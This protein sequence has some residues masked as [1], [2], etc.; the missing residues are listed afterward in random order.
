MM[1][2]ATLHL[3]SINY[4]AI[5]PEAILLIGAVLIVGASSVTRGGLRQITATTLT[6]LASAGAL[7]SALIQ[8]HSITARG[9]LS[10]IAGAIAMDGFSSFFT[11]TIAS[12]L[13]LTTLLG[14]DYLVRE[15]ISTT[16]YHV[17]AL[18]SATGAVIM[19]QAADLMV[20]FVALEILSI[21]LYVLAAFNPRRSESG[22]AALKYFL[23]GGFSSAIFVYGIA[24]T[25]GAT[26]STNFRTISHYLSNVDLV[27]PG[28]LYAGMG[29]ILVGFAFKVAAVPFHLWTPDVYQGSPTPV[30]GFMASIAKVG[31]FAGLL[32]VLDVVFVRQMAVWQPI[33]YALAIASLVLGALVSLRQRNIK[34]MLAYSSINH[35]GFILLGVE[36]GTIR[37]LS[38]SLFYLFT[39]AVMTVGTFGIVSLLGDRGDG[40]HDLTRYRGLARRQPLLGGCLAVLL[41]AQAGIP[42]TTGFIAKFSVVLA[43]IAAGSWPLALIAMITAGIAVSFYL[44]VVLLTL[45]PAPTDHDPTRGEDSGATPA[46][47]RANRSVLLEDVEAQVLTPLRVTMAPGTALAIAVSTAVTIVFGIWPAPLLD[48]ATAAARSLI[49]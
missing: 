43:S 33:V 28:L 24:L 8:W 1:V 42:F 25:Y 26:G 23:L 6:M 20:L 3:P 12:A 30:T 15:G 37:G 48:F 44:H 36:A 34:R 31:A 29:L 13:L 2:A 38:A 39:Y 10:T 14:H 9:P 49:S 21:S 11:I 17:L 7:I 46:T 19:G 47:I 4:L 32:R 40:D 5:A 41:L 16:E 45:S 22:E 35:T 27:H 18:A